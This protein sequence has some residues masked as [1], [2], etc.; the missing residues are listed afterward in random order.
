M[1]HRDLVIGFVASSN[2][3]PDHIRTIEELTETIAQGQKERC[4]RHRRHASSPVLLR[5][6]QRGLGL[7]LLPIALAVRFRGAM[8]VGVVLG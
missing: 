4:S 1:W 6:D 8:A 2:R 7:I 5:N 3:L